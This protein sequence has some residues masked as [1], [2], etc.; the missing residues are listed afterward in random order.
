MATRFAAG[1]EAL[2]PIAASR[3]RLDGGATLEFAPA[4]SG[5]MTLTVKDTGAATASIF[6]AAKEFRPDGGQLAAYA[7]VYQ[8]AEIESVYRIV[9][10]NGGLVLK[11]LKAKPSKLTPAVDDIFSGSAGSVHFV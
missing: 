9:L 2:N 4:N 10:E 1:A 7:G 3:F 6:E 8:S 5:P 11:R